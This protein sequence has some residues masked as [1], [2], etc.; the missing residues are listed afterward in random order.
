MI[1]P[2]FEVGRYRYPRALGS[3]ARCPWKALWSD[4]AKALAPAPPKNRQSRSPRS[5]SSDRAP[6]RNAARAP[7]QAELGRALVKVGRSEPTALVRL[8]PQYDGGVP[9]A[10]LT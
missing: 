4:C 2:W 1:L 10:H 8:R 7:E 6:A 5:F 9:K 3:P